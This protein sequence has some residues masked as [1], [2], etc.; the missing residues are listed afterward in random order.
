MIQEMSQER[1]WGQLVARAWSDQGFKRRLLSDPRAVL[2]E[3]GFDVPEG[4]EIRVLED[5][6]TVRHLTLPPC[7]EGDL[8]DEELVGTAVADSYSGYCGFSGYCG[9]GCRRCRCRCD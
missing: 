9:C 8:V 6:P 1:L 3:H 7:P 4:T 2:A 5:T